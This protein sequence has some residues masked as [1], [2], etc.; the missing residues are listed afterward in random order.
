MPH[1][2]PPHL[3]PTSARKVTGACGHSKLTDTHHHRRI[4]GVAQKPATPAPAHRRHIHCQLTAEP[5]THTGM[6]AA[7]AKLLNLILKEATTTAVVGTVP[8]TVF[9]A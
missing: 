9:P 5:N 3:S 6:I 4:P 8:V 7:L 1:V 2:T